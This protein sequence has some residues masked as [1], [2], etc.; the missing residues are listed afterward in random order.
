VIT[1][2]LLARGFGW[3]WMDPLAGIAGATIIA[4]WSYGLV[5]DTG[6]IFL[7]MNPDRVMTERM[8]DMIEADG[9]LS[10]IVRAPLLGG[11]D[12]HDRA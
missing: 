9:D 11:R 8:R 10:I 2:L 12:R 5:R 6:A 1:G 7:D 3:L 4:S